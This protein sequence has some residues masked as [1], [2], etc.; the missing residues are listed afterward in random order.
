LP[1][2]SDRSRGN[3]ARNGGVSLQIVEEQHGKGESE[4]RQ[5]RKRRF[6]LDLSHLELLLKSAVC[7]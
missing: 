5:E 6:G 4:N 3:A 2:Y 7:W 1:L